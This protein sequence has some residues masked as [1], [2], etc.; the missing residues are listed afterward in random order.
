[1]GLD[2]SVSARALD[3]GI[4]QSMTLKMAEFSKF[5]ERVLPRANEAFN[6]AP[7]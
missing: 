4:R 3:A 7:Q 2:G 6:G 1:M 5:M